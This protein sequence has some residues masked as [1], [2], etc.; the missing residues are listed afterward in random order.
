[1]MG[2]MKALMSSDSIQKM[3][4]MS[5]GKDLHTYLGSDIPQEY[6]GSRP[7]LEGSA[8]TVKFDDGSEGTKDGIAVVVQDIAP[9]KTEEAPEKDVTTTAAAPEPVNESKPTT[10]PMVTEPITTTAATDAP[11][12]EI[13][14]T[15]AASKA[16]DIA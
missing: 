14:T 1:M 15:G 11:A 3:T 2:A 16:A 5:N 6:G 13:K 4:W 8:R 7:S 9:T 12:P 10:T